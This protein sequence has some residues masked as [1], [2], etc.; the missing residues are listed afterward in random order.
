ME[1]LVSTRAL[2]GSWDFDAESMTLQGMGR[3]V[4]ALGDVM[5]VRL[6]KVDVT[7]RL[8]DFEPEEALFNRLTPPRPVAP[9]SKGGK[10]VRAQSGKKARPAGKKHRRKR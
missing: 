10:K 2:G 8:I 5:R 1:G 3:R 6:T 4:I 7:R 9:K